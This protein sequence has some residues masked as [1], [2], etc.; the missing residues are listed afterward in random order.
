MRSVSHPLG[1]SFF[2]FFL[3]CSPFCLACP[4]EYYYLRV[5]GNFMSLWLQIQLS[6]VMKIKVQGYK[7]TR[8]EL[9]QKQQQKEKKQA[10]VYN[11]CAC[12]G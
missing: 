12:F 4:S 11:I 7:F 3:S 6:F 8:L 10:F 9:R 2:S 5:T 1:S